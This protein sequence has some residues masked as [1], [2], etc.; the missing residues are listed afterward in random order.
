MQRIVLTLVFAGGVSLGLVGVLVLTSIGNP[1]NRE[2]VDKDREDS[3]V[4][5]TMLWNLVYGHDWDTGGCKGGPDSVGWERPQERVFPP[6]V[7][8]YCSSDPKY[9][10]HAIAQMKEVGVTTLL[11]SWYGR[12]D[13]DFDGEIESIDFQGNTDAVLKV[14]E[15]LRGHEPGI[16]A[17]VMV[18]PFFLTADP[19]I[20][21]TD[22]SVEQRQTIL[23]YVWDNFYGVFPN[24]TFQWDGKPLLVNWKNNEGQ[25]SLEVTGD[26]RFTFREWGVLEEGADW[27]FTA[28]LGLDGMKIGTDGAIWI[29]PRFDEFYLWNQGALP[30]DKE[31]DN[32]IRLDPYLKEGLYDRAW[33]KVY[34]NRDRIEMVMLYGWNPWA[35][36]AAIEPSLPDGDLL[37]RKTAWYYQRLVVGEEY[38]I[39]GL[40]TT[41]LWN[42]TADLKQFI[43][44]LD[45]G[46]L[47]LAEGLSVD[48]FLASR[49]REAQSLIEA[50]L[51]RTY[52]AVDVPPGLRNIH[53]RL[54]SNIYNYILMNKRNPV[55]QVGEFN[56]QL[57]DD[58]IF[59]DALKSDLALYR[60]RK[61]MRVLYP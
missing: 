7:G 53:L 22:V 58:S 11:L 60:Q 59:T 14:F 24:Q 18:E 34:E 57:N 32:L 29:A 37:L 55:M 23:N 12:G 45:A 46:E 1:G 9:I 15:H 3:N 33:E 6:E 41:G 43:G 49:L 44:N 5:L 50:K 42:Q 47:G 21:P 28:H 8:F 4:P 27:E 56:F 54:S 25:W 52:S 13:V 48:E 35:E 61:P 26:S 16:N 19:K 17:A 2:M 36:A 31:Y 30:P 10:A 51:G 39:F 40:D 38:Q 20:L